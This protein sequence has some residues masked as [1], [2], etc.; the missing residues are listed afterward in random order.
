MLQDIL[1]LTTVVVAA[2]YTI[3]SF[4]KSISD[5]IGG[6]TSGCSGCASGSSCQIKDLAHHGSASK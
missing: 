1:A 4:Y 6:K 2:G 3:Y 5:T